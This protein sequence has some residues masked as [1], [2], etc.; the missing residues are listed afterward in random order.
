MACISYDPTFTATATSDAVEG[1]LA[2]ELINPPI[3]SDVEPG[4]PDIFAFSMVAYE[5]L[6]GKLPFDGQSR[7]MAALSI[8]QE[9][10]PEFPQNA[11]G[12]GLTAQMQ[13]LLRRCWRHNPM[14]RPT[15]DEVVETLELLDEIK[16]VQ[17][18]PS[19]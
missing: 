15:I 3:A 16:C 4:P 10:R 9:S 2:P 17:R 18:S 11:E 1:P 5:V 7:A 8:S 12:T 6:T 13:D 19:E 14:E